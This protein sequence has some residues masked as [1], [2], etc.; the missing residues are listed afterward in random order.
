VIFS[1]GRPQPDDREHLQQG[2]EDEAC[3]AVLNN[4][5]GD[6]KVVGHTVYRLYSTTFIEKMYKTQEAK[7]T[8]CW[9]CLR[10]DILFN[11][12]YPAG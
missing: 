12:Y 11:K 1:T 5:Y 8:E 9:P 6:G 4:F 7:Y 10:F 3:L 2:G